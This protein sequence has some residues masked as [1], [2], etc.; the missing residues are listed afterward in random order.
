MAGE[1]GEEGGRPEHG[2]K[3]KLLVWNVHGI[4]GRSADAN[5]ELKITDHCSMVKLHD[6]TVLTK[7]RSNDASRLLQ[8]LLPGFT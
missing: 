1:D 3:L 8:H 7:T 5:T 4:G 6:V 2:H